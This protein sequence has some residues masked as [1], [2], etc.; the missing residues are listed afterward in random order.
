MRDVATTRVTCTE[1][2]RGRSLVSFSRHGLWIRFASTSGTV[3]A[4]DEVLAS[5]SVHE[6]PAFRFSVCSCMLD[7][8]D[9]V[10]LE[11]VGSSSITT[12][13]SCSVS[14]YLRVQ[15]IHGDAATVFVENF[16]DEL[17]ASERRMLFK[18]QDKERVRPCPPPISGLRLPRLA[19][20]TSTAC[21]RLRFRRHRGATREIRFIGATN[22]PAESVHIP[23]DR[24][25]ALPAPN[26]WS[27]KGQ[28]T[29][30]AQRV[31]H[32]H[33]KGP[34]P[35]DCHWPCPSDHRRSP[36]LTP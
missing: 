3:F 31:V 10:G 8:G 34:P 12:R 5:S 33:R 28:S 29:R 25:G 18:L 4:Q 19:I 20:G 24:S 14:A 6:S 36:L 11:A 2:A 23:N 22:L 13:R 30:V 16:Y 1:V 17:R 35:G 15:P 26:N 9:S 32:G 7:R 27:I 21:C